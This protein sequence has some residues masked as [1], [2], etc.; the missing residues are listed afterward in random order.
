MLM[1]RA[2]LDQSILALLDQHFNDHD[3]GVEEVNMIIRF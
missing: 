3:I 1:W 2:Q